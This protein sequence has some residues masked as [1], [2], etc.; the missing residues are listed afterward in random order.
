MST[1]AEFHWGFSSTSFLQYL[2]SP[3]FVTHPGVAAI[4]VSKTSSRSI[5]TFPT[6]GSQGRG[7]GTEVWL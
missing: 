1:T 2:V 7:R 5:S 6:G 3:G 4:C